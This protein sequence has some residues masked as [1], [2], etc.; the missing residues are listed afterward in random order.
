[1][2]QGYECIEAIHPVNDSHE[3]RRKFEKLLQSL[4]RTGQ[5]YAIVRAE[6][7]KSELF[8]KR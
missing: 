7:G 8:V 1:M 6:D 4:S 3:E 2:A 5:I